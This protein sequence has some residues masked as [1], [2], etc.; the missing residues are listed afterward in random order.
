MNRFDDA[1]WIKSSRSASANNCVMVAFAG[2]TKQL[3]AEV[4]IH[5]S[6]NPDLGHFV[7]SASTWGAFLT[8]V[9]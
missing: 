3:S 7:V 9:K 6:K 8:V 4:G 2:A 1:N 5:D